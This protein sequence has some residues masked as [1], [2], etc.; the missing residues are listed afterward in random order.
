VGTKN[1]NK[2]Q[3][4]TSGGRRAVAGMLFENIYVMLYVNNAILKQEPI[5]SIIVRAKA[6]QGS[7]LRPKMLEGPVH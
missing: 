1:G 7:L 5:M 6:K 4:A 2:C 3:P